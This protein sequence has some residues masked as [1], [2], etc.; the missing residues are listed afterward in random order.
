MSWDDKQDQWS[1]EI[2]ASHPLQT[3]DHKSYQTAMEMV[4]NRHSKRALVDMTCHHLH[5]I[6]KLE[7]EN[8]ALRKDA[9]RYRWLRDACCDANFGVYANAWD[10]HTRAWLDGRELDAAI[11]AALKEQSKC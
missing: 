11:D 10:D 9:E 2:A 8:E 7:R 1:E 4:G 3:G 6:A 5:R